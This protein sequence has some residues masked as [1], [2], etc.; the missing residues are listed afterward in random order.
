MEE[1]EVNVKLME[2]DAKDNKKTADGLN[3]LHLA[4]AVLVRDLARRKYEYEL[5]LISSVVSSGRRYG[6]IFAIYY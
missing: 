4:V 3:S 6:G 1:T 5:L 2:R